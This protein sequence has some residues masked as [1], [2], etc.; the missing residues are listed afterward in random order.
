MT[1]P[2]APWIDLYAGVPRTI[3]PRH[4]TGLAM[5]LANLRRGSERPLVHYFGTTLSAGEIDA[6]S[7]AVAVALG[8]AGVGVGDRVA[9]YLQNVPQV[10]VSVLAAWK[11][12]AVLVPCNPM[13]R[14]QELVKILVDS[15]CRVLICHDDL[16][17]DV[18]SKV[19]HSTAVDLVITTA[20]GDL[21]Q[22]GEQPALL[23][24]LTPVETGSTVAWLD[25]LEM[26]RG[27]VPDPV[28]LTGD[29][30]ALMVYTSGT[31]GAPKA[32]MCTHANV[33]FATSVYQEWLGITS[34][35]VIL[36]LA[37]LFH[38]TGL[39]GHV[40]LAMLAG[41]PLVLFYRFD[42]DEA[43]RLAE[44]HRASF[45]VSAVTAFIALLNSPAM[46]RYDL[47]SLRKVYTGGAPT[48]P[49]ALEDWFQRTGSRIH[50]MY[51]LTEVTS[52]A[53]MT[54][55]GGRPPVDPVTGVISIGVPVFNTHVR[56][57]NEDG[58]TAANRE[59]GELL[60]SGPQ[61]IPGYWQKPEETAKT[62][63][64]GELRTGD[65]GF[66]DELGWFYLVD[67][68][69]DMIVASGFKVWPR[70]VEEILYQHEAVREAAV[71]GVPDPYRGETVKA[72]ISLK[73][74]ASVTADEIKA[75]ARVRMAAYK[76]PRV[77]EIVDELPKTTSGKI[78]RRAVQPVTGDPMTSPAPLDVTYA[79]LRAALESR[80]VIELG[81]TW[82]VLGSGEAARSGRA[83]ELY[84]R[85][86]KM[87][88]QV[89]A[90]GEFLDRA[91]FLDAN[92]SYHQYL[93]G[94]AD[95]ERLSAGFRRLGLRGLFE[96]ALK[97]SAAASEQVVLQHER[98]TDAV[99]AGNVRGAH[100]AI[101]AWAEAARD[102]I[103]AALGGDSADAGDPPTV[104][105]TPPD[106]PTGSP[107]GTV[108]PAQGEGRAALGRQRA[109]LAE[110]LDARAALEIGILR[111]VGDGMT[112]ADREQLVARLVARTPLVRGAD[113]I[114][115]TR[116]VHADDAF[117][118]SFVGV[119][120]NDALL[121]VYT[122]FGIAE[123]MQQ[124]MGAMLPA[125][126]AVMD[127][128]R[129]LTDALLIGDTDAA[130]AAIA[131]EAREV[132]AVLLGASWSDDDAALHP[133]S[134]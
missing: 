86:E 132:R 21:L 59:V 102:R 56:I 51:G 104:D 29:D 111:L 41:S 36:G 119:L 46:G 64:G 60:I 69:K 113:P 127:D 33:V 114:H 34:D 54:P 7:D 79:E 65:V 63:A 47:S 92:D 4:L 94:L 38:V 10:L 18:A 133:M 39:I 45:T 61:V 125:A 96:Q 91:A 121:D 134:R 117:H 5:F 43:C 88:A 78:L 122:S 1:E 32:A 55:F 75:F 81:V 68:K 13:L 9:M 66:M 35:D 106:A 57:V 109:G 26:R 24:G 130:S 112:V 16:Y 11:C 53:H 2:S 99:A 50:P 103:H 58:E 23:S 124:A 93:V 28:E 6:Q 40:A 74:G 87:L 123:L 67:R 115:V 8:A 31:T 100:E 95:N 98:L 110:A 82:L 80:A 22:A 14:D 25:I 62:L 116:Y 129:H 37:P 131:A 73:A 126:R 85:L 71:V 52:P 90:D 12:G 97:D 84:D 20:A 72:I 42:A 27:Q 76:Y 70:E 105:P 19:V 17:A 44:K 107:A 118:R 120:R 48:P 83:V 49:G 101:I 15:G 3:S 89:R 128:H 77:V 30:V 108:V